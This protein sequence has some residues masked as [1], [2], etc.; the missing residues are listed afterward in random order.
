MKNAVFLTG[1]T[2]FLGTEI[3]AELISQTDIQSIP[4]CAPRMRP[5]PQGG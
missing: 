3:A 1:G 5:M 2:G 4:W